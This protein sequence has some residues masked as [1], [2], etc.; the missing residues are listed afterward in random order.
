MRSSS[1]DAV[2]VD[3]YTL[4]LKSIVTNYTG[5][6]YGGRHLG[7]GDIKNNTL[8][9]ENG[10]VLEAT[11]YGGFVA[12]G[13]PQVKG[14]AIENH[15]IVDGG[16][17]EDIYGGMT[18]TEKG[19]VS[20]NTVEINDNSTI[21]GS[22]YGG[23][24]DNDYTDIDTD[25][26]ENKVTLRGTKATTTVTGDII[27]GYVKMSAIDVANNGVTIEG[28]KVSGDV[29]GAKIGDDGYAENNVVTMS[30]LTRSEERRV[31]KECRSR[32][33]PYH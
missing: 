1:D 15:V 29:F 21:N 2:T 32:W 25:V 9:I 27:G 31:G 26:K 11:G 17:T 16:K 13:T 3:G 5:E 10:A 4:I 18:N 7:E 30:G 24:I 14:S 23:A 20:K 12:G 33:S 19:K 8:K 28:G 22:V 6:L